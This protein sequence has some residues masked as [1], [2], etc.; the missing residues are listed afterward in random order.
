VLAGHHPAELHLR[1]RNLAFGDEAADF[2]LDA[3]VFRFEAELDQDLGVFET[4][5]LAPIVGDQRIESGA[6]ALELLGA[7]LI[8]PEPG[9]G[10]LLLERRET[11]GLALD[12]KDA[13]GALRGGPSGL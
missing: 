12:V 3:V 5:V 13:P 2:V 7:L 6:L 4:L 9:L 11:V 1:E 10:A 8:V